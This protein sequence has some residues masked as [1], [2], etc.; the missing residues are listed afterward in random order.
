[1]GD[2]IEQLFRPDYNP[3]DEEFLGSGLSLHG[4]PLCVKIGDDF[5]RMEE[6]AQQRHNHSILPENLANPPQPCSENTS[7]HNHEN[8]M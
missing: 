3:I 8:C 2:W 7:E 5:L 1:M 6:S 4:H